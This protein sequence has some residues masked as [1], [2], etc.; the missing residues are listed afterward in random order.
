[1]MAEPQ[2]RIRKGYFFIKSNKP[3]YDFL[4]WIIIQKQLVKLYHSFLLK[5]ANHVEKLDYELPF[6][7][8]CTLKQV[9]MIQVPTA[10]AIMKKMLLL[11][12]YAYDRWIIGHVMVYLLR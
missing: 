4:V 3:Q 12:N 5:V 11:T 6:T 9:V 1:M 10:E 7:H 2:S 8:E